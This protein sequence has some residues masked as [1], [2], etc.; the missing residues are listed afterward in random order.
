MGN[1]ELT[2]MKNNLKQDKAKRRES[3]NKKH[4]R[5]VGGIWIDPMSFP[6]LIE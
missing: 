6:T 4:V 5:K 1:Q 2:R 3:L